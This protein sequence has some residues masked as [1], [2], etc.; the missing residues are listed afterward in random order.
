MSDFSLYPTPTLSPLSVGTPVYTPVRTPVSTS[1]RTSVSTSVSTSVRTPAR[2]FSKMAAADAAGSD[3][4]R[5][6][7]RQYGG[8]EAEH[9]PPTVVV[10]AEQM[11]S[12]SKV[13]PHA[14]AIAAALAAELLLVHVVE[15][16]AAGFAPADPFEWDLRRRE[17]EAFV[18]D[19]SKQYQSAGNTI[20]TRVLQGRSSDQICACVIDKETDIA[21]LCRSDV[22]QSGH[23]GQTARRVLE[24]AA[25]S[26]LMI[27][28]NASC[29]TS[30]V[31]YKRILVP[32]D[33]SPR[34]ESALPVAKKIALANAAEI[35]LVHAIPEP[36]LTETVPLESEDMELK[37][38]LMLRNEKV[39]RDY[40]E[41]T[42]ENIRS[43]GF[44]ASTAI[45]TGGD[46]R[47]LLTNAIVSESGDLLVIASHGC[48][49][50]ADV[51]TGDVAGYILAHSPIPVLMI[52]RPRA[53]GNHHIY[54]GTESQGVRRPAGAR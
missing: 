45:L 16:G 49:G 32:L 18:S 38:R 51:S 7:A 12:A 27:P 3:P 21:A 19:L 11:A 46:V 35:V 30:P 6:D 31:S 28:A 8:S 29:S 37:H 9:K 26:V 43:M 39:A 52:R 25:S 54:R 42:C 24:M 47:R 23:I 20:A 15:A 4:A 33:G 5:S 44:A 40:L 1:V 34:A 48:S 36:V 13:M 14:Q 50:Y 10:C 53:N 22:E 41:R 2:M 17:A